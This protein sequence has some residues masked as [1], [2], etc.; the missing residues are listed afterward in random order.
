MIHSLRLPFHSEPCYILFSPVR[1]HS[2]GAKPPLRCV[3]TLG[4]NPTYGNEEK[5]TPRDL[6][7]KIVTKRFVPTSQE[8]VLFLGSGLFLFFQ[9]VQL[10]VGRLL[11]MQKITSY[12]IISKVQSK[13]K[14]A[15][16]S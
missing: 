9:L 13:L 3:R 8:F 4:Y 14:S 12:L 5:I 11:G 6:Q 10:S 2:S 1:D 7:G 15:P 16:L